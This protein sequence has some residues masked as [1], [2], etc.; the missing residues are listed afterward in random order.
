[1]WHAQRL[2]ESLL[3]VANL[4]ALISEMIKTLPEQNSAMLKNIVNFSL[5]F[6]TN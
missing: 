6:S 4:K 2:C 1:V 5:F 3:K